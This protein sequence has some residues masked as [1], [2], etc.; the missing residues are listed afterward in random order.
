[1][2]AIARVIDIWGWTKER[3]TQREKEM[4]TERERETERLDPFQPSVVD[5]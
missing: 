1:M 2:Q 5:C 3:D 4:D